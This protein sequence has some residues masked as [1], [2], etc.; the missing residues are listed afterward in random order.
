GAGR[1]RRAC[2]RGRSGG[3]K[4][5]RPSRPALRADARPYPGP[6]GD[7]PPTGIN[8]L[9]IIQGGGRAEGLRLRG[10]SVFELLQGFVDAAAHGL[11]LLAAGRV[12]HE[13]RGGGAADLDRG[14]DQL[15]PVVRVLREGGE[16]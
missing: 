2:A 3:E 14:F 6:F 4:R 15:D 1:G 13:G 11:V 7:D 8:S 9:F 5:R 16:A 10:G 12:A